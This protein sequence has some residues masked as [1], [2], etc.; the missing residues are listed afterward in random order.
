MYGFT[1]KDCEEREVHGE[2]TICESTNVHTML[3]L[4]PAI[5]KRLG[6]LVKKL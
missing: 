4:D 2:V 5:I 1:V 3:S 6:A